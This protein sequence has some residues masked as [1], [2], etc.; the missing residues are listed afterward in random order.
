M[1]IILD[2]NFIY[3]A[4]KFNVDLIERLRKTLQGETLH[5]YV[6]ESSLDELRS[7]GGKGTRALEFAQAHCTLLE[8]AHLYGEEANDKLVTLLGT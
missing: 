5:F 3:M 6:T 2:G 7:L 1:Q 4:L 8:D